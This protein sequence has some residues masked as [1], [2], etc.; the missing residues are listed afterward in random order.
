M[1]KGDYLDFL[2]VV[3]Y[4]FWVDNKD[5]KCYCGFLVRVEVYGGRRLIEFWYKFFLRVGLMY[6]L[7]YFGYVFS[8]RVYDCDKYFY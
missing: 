2:R 7:I 1:R 3:G 5:L 4:K 6:L 8:F